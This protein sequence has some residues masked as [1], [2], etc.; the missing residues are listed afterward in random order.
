MR[1]IIVTG[2]LIFICYL[3][4]SSVLRFFAFGG[5]I[6]NLLII[7]T[8]SSGFM[9]GEKAG[10]WT[11]FLCGFLVDLFSVYG[12]Q[13]ITGDFLGFYALLYMLI[14]YI[15]GKCNSLFF[16]EDIKLPLI[17]ILTSDIALNVVC[18]IIMFLMRARLNLQY[19]MLHIILPEAVYTILIAFAVYPLF[20]WI[21]KKL[22][23]AERG[24]DE[25]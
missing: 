21:N 12:N 14:G 9:R 10:I 6:P 17:M 16:P 18:Y 13:A 15:N 19:Y 5:I 2:L 4:Q 1:R 22:E 11:G 24:S 25:Y 20:L 23:L 7:L 3:L 8:A